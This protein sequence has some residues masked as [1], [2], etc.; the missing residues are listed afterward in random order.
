MTLKNEG[1]VCE[2]CKYEHISLFGNPCRDC[3]IETNSLW[4]AKDAKKD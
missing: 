4:E 3:V 2:T 1:R